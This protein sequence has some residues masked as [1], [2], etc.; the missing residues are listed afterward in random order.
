MTLRLSIF[1]VLAI[2]CFTIALIVNADGETLF[3]AGWFIWTSAGLIAWAIEP[4]LPPRS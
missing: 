2:V 4:L 3:G 1:R